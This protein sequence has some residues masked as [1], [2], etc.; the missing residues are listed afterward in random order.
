MPENI[1]MVDDDEM[2]IVTFKA[3]LEMEGYHVITALDSNEAI[4]KLS[5]QKIDVAILD[6]NL[7]GMNGIEL[8]YIINENDPATKIIFISGSLKIHELAEEQDYPVLKTFSKPID[9]ESLL[10]TIKSEYQTPSHVNEIE[11]II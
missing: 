2:I 8:G 11:M 7:P 4:S 6:Y 10:S 3:I 9:I 5:G 1:L